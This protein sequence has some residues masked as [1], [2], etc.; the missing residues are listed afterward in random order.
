[1]RLRNSIIKLIGYGKG[2]E[3]AVSHESR[4]SGYTTVLK[5]VDAE[6]FIDGCPKCLTDHY[7]TN[8]EK[9]NMSAI[10]TLEKLRK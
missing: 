4:D 3:I 6:E 8:I 2:G 1:M 10:V 5:F 9:N 7:L